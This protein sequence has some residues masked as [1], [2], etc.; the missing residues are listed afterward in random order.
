MAKKK[1]PAKGTCPLLK[2]RCI[3]QRCRWYI[4]LLGTD[5][6]KGQAVDKW[7]CAVEFIPVLLIE[8]A[9]EVRQTAAAVESARNESKE[10]AGLLAGGMAVVAQAAREAA[11]RSNTLTIHQLPGYDQGATFQRLE[12][13]ADKCE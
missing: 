6:Q 8:N 4:Q 10:N 1:M 7:G 2:A 12:R 11:E 3:E 13:K 9:K 5:P